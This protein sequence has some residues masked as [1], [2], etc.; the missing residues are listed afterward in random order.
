MNELVSIITPSFNSEKYIKETILSVQNQTYQNWEMIIIDD[1]ST[2][3]TLN[4]I[5][6]IAL[7]DPRIKI[8]ALNK[9][10]GSGIARNKGI[11]VAKG[12]YLTF[13]DADDIWNKN[14]I[15]NQIKFL[16]INHLYFT[17]CF[18]SLIDENSKNIA[19]YISAPNPLTLKQLK[20]CNH[21]GNLTGIY[22][23]EYFGKIYFSKLRKRQDWIMWLEIL[24]KI[25]IA[26]PL[27]QYL[28]YYRKRKN[29]LSAN[30]LKLIKYN[31]NVYR[32]YWN[33]S[34]INSMFRMFIFLFHQLVLKKKY[35]KKTLKKLN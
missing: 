29:S 32:Y 4:S 13:I 17:F 3:N 35:I 27:P 20:Y 31:Y 28:A 10:V 25:K 18:Y 11:D 14:K 30:K 9:N 6:D 19:K 12:K 33:H 21:I 34:T 26:Y 2:D 8:I 5:N 24:K 1:C 7:Q 15:E 22:D 16:K 23:V